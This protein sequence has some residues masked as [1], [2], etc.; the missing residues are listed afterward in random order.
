VTLEFPDQPRRILLCMARGRAAGWHRGQPRHHRPQPPRHRHRPHRSPGTPQ[1]E[2][3]A[4]GC[5]GQTP[6]PPTRT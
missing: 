1:G 2:R 5:P 6:L 3:A 4:P